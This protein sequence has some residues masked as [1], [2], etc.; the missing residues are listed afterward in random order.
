MVPNKCTSARYYDDLEL[1]ALGT[2]GDC[3]GFI[4]PKITLVKEIAATLDVDYDVI[5]LGTCVKKAKLT[6]QCPL[7]F[8]KVTKLV[9]QNF[10]KELVVGAHDY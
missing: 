6:G 1:V 3:P 4:M 10:G 9:K 2:C 5:H 7:D 8:E